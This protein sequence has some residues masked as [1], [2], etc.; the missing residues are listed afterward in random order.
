MNRDELLASL[1]L[2]I[3]D[4]NGVYFDAEEGSEGRYMDWSSERDG[5]VY[6]EVHD[7][8]DTT[9]SVHISWPE[10]ER[11]QRALTLALLKRTTS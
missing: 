10:M 5:G 11:L 1:T 9:A 6:F 4:L 2:G 3:E 8:D 7:E